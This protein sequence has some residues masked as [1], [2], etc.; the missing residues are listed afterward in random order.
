MLTPL[1]LPSRRILRDW[2]DERDWKRRWRDPAGFFNGDC[3]CCPKC[4]NCSGLEANTTTHLTFV[5]TAGA[6]C[7]GLD[8]LVVTLTFASSHFYAGLGGD[9]GPGWFGS[10]NFGGCNSGIG[11]S[12]AANSCGASGCSSAA[13][14]GDQSGA[15]NPMFNFTGGNNVCADIATCQ[16]S[17][18]SVKFFL[19]IGPCCGNNGALYTATWTL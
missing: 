4:A 18:L 13:M 6:A 15:G 17:P 10:I 7:A 2:R 9:R 3:P 8:G 12:C 14:N 5:R 19:V 16:C 1:F 11:V